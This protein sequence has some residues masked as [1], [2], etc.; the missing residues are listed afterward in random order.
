MF[1]FFNDTATTWI[2]TYCHTRS[3]PT[4]FRSPEN[5]DCL[6]EIGVSAHF[7]TCSGGIMGTSAFIPLWKPARSL[8]I[9]GFSAALFFPFGLTGPFALFLPTLGADRKSVVVG[10]SVSVRVDPG[11]RRIIKKKKR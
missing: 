8:A 11:G 2:Y 4:L 1:F 6:I 7:I 3:L 10:K 5:R 9:M